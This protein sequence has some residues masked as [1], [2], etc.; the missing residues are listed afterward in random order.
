[1]Y[2]VLEGIDGAGKST[3]ITALKQWLEDSGF[4]VETFV[5]PT[6]SE[7]GILIRKMLQNPSATDENIQKTLGL[8]FAADRLLLMDKI[9]SEEYCNKVIISDRSFYSSLAYQNPQNWIADINK[10]AKKP[11]IVL[12]LDLDVD[13]A[14]ERCSGEDEFEKKSFLVDVKNKYLDLAKNDKDI[15]KIINANNGP[16]KV[17]SDIRKAVAPF[18]GICVSG[19]D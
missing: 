2:I 5:E 12:L 17:Q 19:I 16:K 13:I 8:L 1:M 4:E 6:D 7:I 11:D 10:F 15:F 18:L 9:D 3:Q 14:I